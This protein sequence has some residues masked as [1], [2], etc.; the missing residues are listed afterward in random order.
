M[1]ANLTRRIAL[2]LQDARAR[3][4]RQAAFAVIRPKTKQLRET[5]AG[6]GSR[7]RAVKEYSLAHL[8]ELREAAMRR[9]RENGFRVFAAATAEDAVR[10]ILAVA[11]EGPVVKSK[12]NAGKEIGLRQAL[13]RA[14]VEVVETDL[15]DR[16]CQLS[17]TAPSHP[18]VPSIHLTIEE[19]TGL[20]ARESGMALEPRAEALVVAARQTLR[21]KLLSARVGLSG[22]NAIT[23]DTGSVVLTE[24][25]GNIR[26]VTSLPAVHIVLAGIEKI[27][28]TLA[29][30]L[31]V[32]RATAIYGGGNEIGTYISVL[33]GLG[34]AGAATGLAGG[35]FG[36]REVH[37]VLLDNGRWKALAA[38]YQEALYCLNCGACLNHCPVYAEIGGAYGDKHLGGRGVVFTAFHQDLP[39][40]VNAGLSLC[41]N[42]RGCVEVC[43]VRLDTP[44]LINRLR[45]EAAAGQRR[46]TAKGV[47]LRRFFAARRQEPLVRLAAAAQPLVFARLGE[48]AQ[49]LRLARGP[50]AERVFP[51]LPGRS[52]PIQASA[53]PASRVAFFPGCLVRH[54]Y[55]EIGEAV[56]RVLAA[57]GVQ[58]VVAGEECCGVPLAA[59]GYPEEARRL[60]LANAR[61]LKALG[62]ERVITC[63]SSCGGAFREEY[64]TLLGAPAEALP[65][66]VSWLRENVR[67]I[68]AFLLEDLP[69]L[70]PPAGE[71]RARVTYHDPCHLARRLGVR[72]QPRE[73]LR[74]LP[75][76]E[77]VEMEE[78][79]SCCGCA[80]S[81]SFEHY[82]L[83]RRINQ[84]KLG[85]LRASGAQV[86]ATGCPACI[87]HFRDGLAQEEDA[88]QVLHPVQL[89]DLAYRGGEGGAAR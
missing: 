35:G 52:L 45:A 12:T 76:V 17:G 56:L 41:L 82:P 66:P 54:V 4:G 73:L 43:P 49:K 36:P 51:R 57:N 44:S 40:A 48:Q 78:A 18:L 74:R 86:L 33:S 21:K 67:D 88:V 61:A 29:D 85:H 27:V 64:A 47:A 2:G 3:A 72:R 70:Q 89:L 50:W 24:N 79:D 63:C 81:F 58:A 65:E 16:L 30:A 9:M 84:R 42:C 83:A 31:A 5:Y 15:G 75:G 32:A 1:A 37:V 25:E 39:A 59:N 71:V 8:P 69:A 11:G 6:L 55:P 10:Y 23:A 68:S 53:R 22:A 60:A 26:A 38:G 62:V 46:P 77:F 34:W 14:G 28:P 19:I 13:E 7:V 80:G 87:M 20:L